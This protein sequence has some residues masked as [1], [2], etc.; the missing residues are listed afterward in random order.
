M[1]LANDIV[2]YD[3]ILE[4]FGS[5]DVFSSKS[6]NRITSSDRRVPLRHETKRF[7]ETRSIGVIDDTLRP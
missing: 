3:V 4:N 6:E 2:N 1:L 5:K 7:V